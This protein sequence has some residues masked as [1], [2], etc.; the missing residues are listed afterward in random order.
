MYK[1]DIFISHA[2]RVHP[3]WERVVQI[4]DNL[5]NLTWRNFSVPWHDPALRPSDPLGYSLIEKVFIAQIL[6]SNICIIIL[7]LV[8]RKSNVR[9]IEKAV[10][11]AKSNDIPLISVYEDE[12][13][14]E[15]ASR[16]GISKILK[17]DDTSI[18]KVVHEIATSAEFK[19]V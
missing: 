6:P 3:E 15:Y 4:I 12:N 19:Y 13:Y 1:A 17:L 14:I 9:W 2:W 8:K 18:E 11:I 7:D 5:Q 16:L 10:E